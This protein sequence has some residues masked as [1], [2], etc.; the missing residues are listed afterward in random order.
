MMQAEPP[1]NGEYLVAAYVASTLIL[2]GYWIRLWRMMK[3]S[4]SGRAD[5]VSGKGEG[6][7]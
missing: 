7:R 6:T 5:S 4:M 3:K 2:V 1:S